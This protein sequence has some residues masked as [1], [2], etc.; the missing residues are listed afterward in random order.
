MTTRRITG[1]VELAVSLVLA[2]DTLR[3]AQS[4]T[5]LDAAIT[6]CLQ[7]ITQECEHQIGR[8]LINQQWRVS[9][10]WFTDSIRLDHPPIVSVQSV[11]FYD[12]NGEIQTLDPADYYVDSVTEP[13]YV[14]PAGGRSWPATQDRVHAVA[15]DYTA[16]YG[17][18]EA[19]VPACAKQYILYRLAEQFDPATGEFAKTSRSEYADRLLDPLKV[20]Q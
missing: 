11:K 2:K 14:I 16:G 10:D 19:S 8:A 13:G 17:P 15:V 6:L 12:E 20:Y 9:V 1:P 18:T 5:A 3:I 7:S 4:N